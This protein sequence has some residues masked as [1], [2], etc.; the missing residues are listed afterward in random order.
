MR[1]PTARRRGAL[2]LFRLAAL[3]V[4]VVVPASGCSDGSPPGPG[5]PTGAAPTPSAKTAPPGRAE[6]PGTGALDVTAENARPGT[7]AWKTGLKTGPAHAIEGYADKVAVEPGEPF[8][9]FV[10][11]TAP[12]FTV[13]AYRMGWYGGARGREVWH[14]DHQ[15]GV[16]QHPPVVDPGVNTVHADWQ[17]SLTVTPA[18]GDWPEGSYLLLL[19]SDEGYSTYVP[20]T[21]RSG[22]AQGRTV[23]VN[24]VTT[25]QA[26]NLWGGY[27]L[28][29]G[30]KDYADRARAVSFDRPYDSSGA[31]GFLNFEQPLVAVAERMG[32]PL[33]YA[34]DVDLDAAPERFKGATAVLTLG[35]DE[36]WSTAMRTNA[37]ALRDGGTNLAFLGANAVNRHIR[38]GET[39][40]GPHRLVVCYKSAAEDPMRADD[41][42]E[43]TQD[44]RLPP[45]PRPE[46]D[47][48]GTLYQCFPGNAS[49]V[50]WDPDAWV[51]AGTGVRRGSAFTGLVGVEYD[52]VVRDPAPPQPLQVLSHSPVTCGGKADFANA[53]YYTV[54]SGAGVFS[55]GT[56]RWVCALGSGCGS[57]LDDAA[58]AFATQVT[59]N[60]LRVFAAGPA[61][62]AHPAR[63]NAG[64]LP[65]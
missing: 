32:L 7:D 58:R 37:S 24:A 6:P 9:L 45:H 54:P 62:A 17:P 61:G 39:A 34:T 5:R 29:N 2:L 52:R 20:V 33:A 35:H 14:S 25:W 13:T 31:S 19:A 59:E 64:E 63:A 55:T 43:T 57:F 30:P 40:L 44:W 28:Y 10:S 51:F 50:V 36:Y 22:R 21:V 46:N 42:S 23:L 12:G 65:G 4:A 15:Q 16:K 1:L 60:V 8:R 48:T 18:A 38:F 41:P 27:D 26:Y 53:S 56:M 47:L 49:F 3:L 11:T